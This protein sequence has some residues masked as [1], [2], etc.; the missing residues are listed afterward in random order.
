MYLDRGTTDH[1]SSRPVVNQ[2]LT[3][4]DAEKIL[5]KVLDKIIDQLQYKH[6]K[7]SLKEHTS[8]GANYTSALFSINVTAPDHDTLNLF[9]KVANVNEVFRK[10]MNIDYMFK[11][12]QYVYADLV[13]VYERIQ[14]EHNLSSEH[15]FE[16]PKFYGGESASGEETVVMEDLR[17]KDFDTYSRF[18]PIDWEHAACAIEYLARFHALSFA[19][20]KEDPEKFAKDAEE[21]RMKKR[22]ESE[23]EKLKD[24]WKK[25]V[26]S[27]VNVVKEEHK[28]RVAKLLEDEGSRDA[29][30]KFKTP[31]ST[32]V[33]CHGDYRVS[34]LLFRRLVCYFFI[35][36]Y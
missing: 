21:V 26:E 16:F 17:A 34:N 15:R 11:T 14:D 25:M 6:V 18:K 4:S 31:L 3:M 1:K 22:D 2:P 28:E 33:L 30:Y 10:I 32:T 29:F 13:K 36:L 24:T 8:G 27:A 9:A 20:Q 19:Y 35:F 12:E 23:S 5:R 7:I